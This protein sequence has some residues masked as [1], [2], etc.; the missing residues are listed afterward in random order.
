MPGPDPDAVG[1]EPGPLGGLSFDGRGG[2]VPGA[3]GGRPDPAPAAARLG[4]AILEAPV[5]AATPPTAAAA[6]PPTASVPATSAPA[7]RAGPPVTSAE[8]RF[9]MKSASMARS[10]DAA[11]MASAS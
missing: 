6:A 2:G 9:G 7:P 5:A 4:A 3:D 11:R 1:A 10:S 8:A